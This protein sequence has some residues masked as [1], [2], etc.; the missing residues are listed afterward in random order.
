MRITAW[1]LFVGANPRKKEEA[2]KIQFGDR[3]HHNP[4]PNLPDTIFIS[5]PENNWWMHG[6][7]CETPT[8]C[9]QGWNMWEILEE[10]VVVYSL[11]QVKTR[12][13]LNSTKGGYIWARQMLMV[14]LENNGLHIYVY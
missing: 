7:T 11:V 10:G 8:M 14:A 12:K 9:L 6:Y 5:F 13:S 2:L 3:D 1:N 4:P